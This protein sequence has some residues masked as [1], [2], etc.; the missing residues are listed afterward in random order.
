MLRHVESTRGATLLRVG[1]T[2]KTMLLRV[3][4]T[5][6]TMLLRV[7]SYLGRVRSKEEDRICLVRRYA[8]SVPD[9][10]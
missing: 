9:T 3:G 7:G 2:R 8:R 4:S 10:A 5:G 6:K 1:S